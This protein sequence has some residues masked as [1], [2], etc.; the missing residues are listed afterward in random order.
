MI[1]F[2]TNIIYHVYDILKRRVPRFPEGYNLSQNEVF[3][4]L[5]RY[6]EIIN[7]GPIPITN[8]DNI[9]KISN[10]IAKTLDFAPQS[11]KFN[12]LVVVIMALANDITPKDGSAYKWVH[13]AQKTSS[14]KIP[15][16]FKYTSVVF[17]SAYLL[18]QL[19]AFR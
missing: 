4:I 10:T 7:A 1:T 13:E 17:V 3:N 19:Q 11:P 18:R 6:K 14:L 2:S 5:A 8:R 12:G 16:W 9:L 15:S